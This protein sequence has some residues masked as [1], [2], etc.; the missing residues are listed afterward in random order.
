MP[1]HATYRCPCPRPVRVQALGTPSRGTQESSGLP[2]T[3]SE[4][5]ILQ[6]AAA[7]AAA[8]RAEKGS[9]ELKRESSYKQRM[10]KQLAGCLRQHMNVQAGVRGFRDAAQAGP[11]APFDAHTFPVSIERVSSGDTNRRRRPLPPVSAGQ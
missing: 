7:R 5:S 2:R 4:P 8:E 10:N 3:L 9:A 6:L 1:P 11:S